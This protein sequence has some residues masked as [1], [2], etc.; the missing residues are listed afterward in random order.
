MLAVPR[1]SVEGE[2]SKRFVY[3]VKRGELGARRAWSGARFTWASP[4]RPITKSS[5]GLNEGEMIALPGDVDL[6]DGMVV[7]IMNTDDSAVR[8]RQD[9]N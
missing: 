3:V 5:R 7:R 1:G 6:K 4:I 2:G 8:A 9:G